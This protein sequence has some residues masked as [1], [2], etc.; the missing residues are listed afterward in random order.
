MLFFSCQ[1][2]SKKSNAEGQNQPAAQAS[3]TPPPM[4]GTE[5]LPLWENVD[6]IDYMFYELPISMSYDNKGGIQTS[7]SHIAADQ[8][9]INPVCK[10]MGRIFYGVEGEHVMEADLFF[11]DQCKYFIF[12]KNGKRVH[13]NGITPEGVNFL[14]KVIG[15]VQGQ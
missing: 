1:N 11:N 14:T 8:A 6:L 12:Y 5:L 13:S 2:N 3:S 9:K 10:P 7:L 15:Q 4:T